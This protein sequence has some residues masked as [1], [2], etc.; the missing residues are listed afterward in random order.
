MRSQSAPVHATG[1]HMANI[2]LCLVSCFFCFFA[3]AQLQYTSFLGFSGQRKAFAQLHSFTK[4][5]H[6]KHKKTQYMRITIK[7]ALQQRRGGQNGN[8]VMLLCI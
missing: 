3:L 2:F 6:S 7:K 4:V 8:M 5:T 1:R